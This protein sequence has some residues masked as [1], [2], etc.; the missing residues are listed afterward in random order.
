LDTGLRRTWKR[1]LDGHCGIVNVNDRDERFKEV[2]C[3]IAAVVPKG[4]RKDGGW[5]AE[6]WLSR[7][8]CFLFLKF[9]T[10]FH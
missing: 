4:S 6:E 1:L 5:M 2:P 9:A 3:Q 8:V 7:G 10:T